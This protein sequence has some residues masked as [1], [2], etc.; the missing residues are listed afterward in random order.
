MAVLLILSQYASRTSHT[1]HPVEAILRKNFQQIMNWHKLFFRKKNRQLKTIIFRDR[2]TVKSIEQPMGFSVS[3]MD[4]RNFW[5]SASVCD[6]YITWIPGI[7][8]CLPACVIIIMIGGNPWNGWT[9]YRFKWKKTLS[10]EQHLICVRNAFISNPRL[11]MT[12]IL[13]HYKQPLYTEVCNF[14]CDFL[15]FFING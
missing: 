15:L 3:N 14:Q 13:G 5:I 6:N 4:S 9:S 2:K 10:W 1:H 7:S 11:I 12:K 8:G